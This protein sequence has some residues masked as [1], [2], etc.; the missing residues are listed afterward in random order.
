MRGFRFLHAADLHLDSPFVG[1]SGLPDPIKGLIRESTFAALNE[2]IALAIREEVDFVLLGGDLY[3]AKDR[4]LRA[5]LRFLQAMEQLHEAQIPVFIVHG[6]HDPTDG[7]QA[8]LTWPRNVHVFSSEQAEM[9][10][11]SN[12][13]GEAIARVHGMSYHTS[14]MKHSLIPYFEQLNASYD[15]SS[16]LYEIGLL[17]CNVDG[18]PEH[19]NY[20]PCRTSEL[21]QTG[22]DYWALGHVHEHR[23]V[24]REPWIVY[25][26]NTQGRHMR[27]RGERG[28]CIVEVDEWKN[29]QV[30]FYPLAS[31]RFEEVD[32]PISAW[33]HEQDAIDTVNEI[34]ERER[35]KL[36][37]IQRNGTILRIVFS[38]RGKTVSLFRQEGFLEDWLAEIQ[39]AERWRMNDS[40]VGWVWVASFRTEIDRELSSSFTSDSF[41][42]DLVDIAKHLLND[43]TEMAQFA[44][45]A[46]Q[47]LFMNRQVS[48]YVRDSLVEQRQLLF[49]E[50]L[51]RGLDL[52]HSAEDW[53]DAE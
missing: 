8:K 17:H 49:K 35:E 19:D 39:E 27:E 10:V 31:I 21:V 43:E 45:E 6:N 14:A 4:S 51:H 48:R 33:Q 25:P 12:R 44:E 26:G 22:Y 37:E 46:L 42:T 50:A 16:G 9:V 40:P 28:C 2:M 15:R 7:K 36:A 34:V 1:L 41:V 52:L 29:T 32:L 13:K 38:G 24:H 23:I 18:D 47:P 11:V 30:T 3:D 20:A 53:E 5:Q